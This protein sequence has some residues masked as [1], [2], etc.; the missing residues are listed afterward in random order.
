M[1]EENIICYRGSLDDVLDRYYQ[2][3]RAVNCRTIV[4]L[5][6]DCPLTDPNVIDT[7]IGVFQSGQYAFVANTVPPEGSTF[8]DGM[9]VEA[10]SF[11]T[12]ERAWREAKKPSEREHVTF[13][14]W[15]NPELFSTYRY[16]L[17]ENLTKYRLTVDYPEDFEVISAIL[18]ALYSHKPKFT[19]ADIIHY[20]KEN[21][22]ILARNAHIIP[23]QGWQSALQKDKIEAFKLSGT[24]LSSG[25]G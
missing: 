13:Y 17:K 7:V 4:R 15:Q 3:A 9:D 6:S 16:D 24:A 20:L 18:K 11:E 23:N 22:D 8:P 10:F 21:P 2:A 14:F 25:Q 19:M 1:Q 12:L 5:T